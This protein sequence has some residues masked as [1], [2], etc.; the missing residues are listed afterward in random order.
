MKA[1][2]LS[3]HMQTFIGWVSVD[4]TIHSSITKIFLTHPVRARVT[5][6][7]NFKINKEVIM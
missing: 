6:S 2:L 7:A 3:A 4:G 5:S 1:P